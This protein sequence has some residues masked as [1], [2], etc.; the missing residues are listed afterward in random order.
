MEGRIYPAFFCFRQPRNKIIVQRLQNLKT[1]KKII[2]CAMIT[3]IAHSLWASHRTQGIELFYSKSGANSYTIYVRYVRVCDGPLYSFDIYAQGNGATIVSPANTVNLISTK[4][5]NPCQSIP[6]NGTGNYEERLYEYSL[7]LS[8]TNDCNWK[9]WVQPAYRDNSQNY[10]VEIN[11]NRCKDASGGHFVESPKFLFP[12][13]QDIESNYK[14]QPDDAGDSVSYSLVAGEI[15][16]NTSMTYTGYFSPQKPLTFLGYPNGS[17]QFPAGFHMD[18]D[19]FL[20]FR[21]TILNEKKTIV[22]QATL[23]KKNNGIWEMTGTLKRDLEVIVVSQ[24]MD[25]APL[26]LGLSNSSDT[27]QVAYCAGDSAAISWQS[28]DADGD[29]TYIEVLQAD[30]AISWNTTYPLGPYACLKV[31]VKSDLADTASIEQKFFWIKLTDRGCPYPKSTYYFVSFSPNKPVRSRQ[32]L[33]QSCWDVSVATNVL[34]TGNGSEKTSWYFF[35]DTYHLQ[36]DG[37][38]IFSKTID[39]NKYTLLSN[40]GYFG[41]CHTDTLFKIRG[42]TNF[43][44]ELLG[45]DS[46][47]PGDSVLW[48]LQ[49]H[50]S[51]D[52]DSIYWSN[53]DFP[54]NPQIYLSGNQALL[55]PQ[56]DSRIQVLIR[57]SSRCSLSIEKTLRI[58]HLPSYSFSDSAYTCAGDSVSVGPSVFTNADTAFWYDTTTLF[59]KMEASKGWKQFYTSNISGCSRKDSVWLGV[60]PKPKITNATFTN[61]CQ[62]DS[63][64]PDVTG[65]NPP[66]LVYFNQNLASNPIPVDRSRP[67]FIRVKDQ[68][69][70]DSQMTYLN[71]PSKPVLSG[72][73]DGQMICPD[74]SF[75][76]ELGLVPAGAN[77]YWQDSTHGN[78][79]YLFPGSYSI[80]LVDSNSCHFDYSFALYKSIVDTS[81]FTY[82]AVSGGIE[83]IPIVASGFH[84]WAFGD[85]STSSLAQPVHLY[86]GPGNY[87]VNHRE[88]N[89]DST[90]FAETALNILVLDVPAALRQNIRVYPN[91]FVES[92][93][94]EYEQIQ[95]VK[96]YSINGREMPVAVLMIPGKA[97]IKNTSSLASGEY[98][99][100][101]TGPKESIIIRVRKE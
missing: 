88:Y 6:C 31:F 64:F 75:R 62:G 53:L 96:M 51:R 5:L 15:A 57:D 25:Q 23:W 4:R 101:I 68:H 1:M 32:I 20:R 13:N 2:F 26:I 16:G 83:F 55:K 91:P 95:E 50:G 79:K 72:L 54:Q 98:L 63:F 45:T 84:L 90:C 10:Y 94:L 19:G 12:Y 74:D 73:P 42:L 21:P 66:Y 43:K 39:S 34:Q 92:L 3:L 86:S 69:C 14:V 8:G 93:T 70:A 46:M 33:A 11:F 85:G 44:F 65:G 76:V 22:V 80:L 17:L 100:Q 89:L 30:S 48:T 99:L 37:T 77:V 81:G 24:Q 49:D 9:V 60:Y 87:L 52:I 28:Y 36:Q 7:D 97:V 27:C 78:E 59:P 47:C 58:N 71:V 29:S 41:G 35:D 56:A 40:H 18:T 67:V 61:V 82:K 38:G